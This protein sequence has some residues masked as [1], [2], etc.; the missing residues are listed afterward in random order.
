MLNAYSISFFK[1]IS[2][3]FS[4]FFFCSLFCCYKIRKDK[5]LFKIIRMSVASSQVAATFNKYGL[6]LRW[7]KIWIVIIGILM[8]FLSFCIAGM[9]VGHT[10]Y[11]LRRSTAFGG[12][13]LFLPLLI[14]GLLVLI[15]GFK[16]NLT[17]VRFA[18]VLCFVMI[19]LCFLLIAYDI[20][21]IIDPTRCFFLDCNYAVVNASNSTTN[22]VVTGWPINVL[23]PNYF[24]IDMYAKKIFQ[25]VQILLAALFILFSALYI[26]T[27]FIYRYIQLHQKSVYTVEQRTTSHAT[28]REPYGPS[29]TK[30]ILQI[31]SHQPTATLYSIQRKT[32]SSSPVP[33]A[34]TTKKIIRTRARANSV[35]YDRICTRCM[36]EP[37]MP[38][39]TDFERRNYYSH[40]CM[41]CNYELFNVR[42]KPAA[43]QSTNNRTWKP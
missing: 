27:Y 18:T 39:T 10:I 34:I 32:A 12:F 31:F 37:R 33:A 2:S 16:P 38:L 24:I 11:D 28:A 25:S 3:S 23:W 5:Q 6:I 17:L 15:S 43:T 7:P 21:V 40:L 20:L 36:K 35:S 9:E 19:I 1:K 8:I 30:Q 13:I 4:V 22:V 29:P 26:L 14:C 41:N 42:R